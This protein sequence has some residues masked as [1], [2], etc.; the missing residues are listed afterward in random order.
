[1]DIRQLQYFV[2]I[3]LEGNISKAAKELNIT[4]PPLSHAIKMLEQELNTTLFIRGSRNISLTESGKILYSKAIHL[5]ELHKQSIKEINDLERS[6]KGNLSFGCVSSA[7]MVLMEYGIVP[8][9]R[10]NPQITYELYEKNTY[11]LIE[12]LNSNLIE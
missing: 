2:T 4:Q 1:M 7:H 6:V 5:L 11:E 9:Y 3:V 10:K 8:F 12:L